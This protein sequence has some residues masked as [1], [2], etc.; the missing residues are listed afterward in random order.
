[1]T[2]NKAKQ[3]ALLNLVPTTKTIMEIQKKDTLQPIN[4]KREVCLNGY[5]DNLS[6]SY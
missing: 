2:D 3:G 5:L 4:A 1:M 6:L